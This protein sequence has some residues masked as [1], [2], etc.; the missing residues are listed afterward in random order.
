MKTNY[1]EYKVATDCGLFSVVACSWQSACADVREAFYN[2]T[3]Y[4]PSWEWNP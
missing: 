2:V 3:I 4:P 1:T